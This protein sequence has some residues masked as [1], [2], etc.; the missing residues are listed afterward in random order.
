MDMYTRKETNPNHSNR[1]D[2][3][4]VKRL[5]Q[6]RG[7]HKISLNDQL[8]NFYI[9]CKSQRV[10]D[11]EVVYYFH[12]EHLEPNELEEYQKRFLRLEVARWAKKDEKISPLLHE[13]INGPNPN[14]DMLK[15]Y[16]FSYKSINKNLRKNITASERSEYRLYGGVRATLVFNLKFSRPTNDELEDLCR[17]IQPMLFTQLWRKWTPINLPK[18]TTGINVIGFDEN[19]DNDQEDYDLAFPPISTTKNINQHIL[20]AMNYV[21][22]VRK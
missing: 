14:S 21:A 17:R 22:I 16:V 6:R 5:Y 20:G 12:T 19:T 10:F 11:H 8:E 15:Q 4:E 9:A 18:S 1:I 13:H 2:L 3:A 7:S